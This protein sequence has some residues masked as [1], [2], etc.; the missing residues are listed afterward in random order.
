M[1]K[2][3]DHLPERPETTPCHQTLQDIV[4]DFLE[5]MRGTASFVVYGSSTRHFLYWLGCKRI[6]IASVDIAVVQQFSRHKC[7]CP[8]YSARQLRDRYYINRV[9]HF[10]RFLE[11]RGAIPVPEGIEDID[12]HLVRCADHFTSLGYSSGAQRIQNSAAEHF[13]AWLRV[14]RI[15]WHEVDDVVI[16]RFA[17][18]D[19]RCGLGR[20]NGKPGASAIMKR[21][22]GAARLFAFLT[23]NG[24]AARQIA[25]TPAEAPD[26]AAFRV[27]LE[28]HRGATEK[29]IER[30]TSEAAR[31]LPELEPDAAGWT[32]VGIRNVVLNQPPSRSRASVRMTATVLR[33]FLRFLTASG[34]CRPELM[35]AVPSVAPRRLSNL[36]RYADEATIAR[37]IAAC[38]IRTPAELRDR[39]IILLLARL[40]LRAGDI[41]QLRIGDL[42]WE[43]G[44]LRVHGK[45]RQ[46]V[47]LPLP[48]DAGDAVLAYLEHARPVVPQERVFLGIA[49]PFKPF[50]SSSEISGI[51]S[52]LLARAD[53]CGV[54][55]GAHM[56]R[57]SLATSLLRKGAGLE[58]IGTIL[59]HQSPDTT[60]IYAKVDVPMLQQ[61]A[62]PWPGEAAC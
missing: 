17:R 52:R 30:Y 42:D 23:E 61:I 41:C 49:A 46:S 59:R 43:N 12:R 56:F 35:H 47:R 48:Q 33:C 60:A 55:S 4:R 15:R 58:A 10:V 34:R 19:C 6:P 29:T 51:L 36:P 38:G 1:K 14:T 5:P 50:A 54:P 2:H 57:H 31:W 39:A 13:V 32:A 37:I 25:A 62:Q 28:R 3:T 9:G 40:G 20:K 26:L 7:G 8:R 44:L 22:R 24:I 16:D 53:I 27:W 18:H 21:R 11:G 45:G